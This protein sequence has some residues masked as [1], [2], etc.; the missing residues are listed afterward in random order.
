MNPDYIT[1]VPI[2]SDLSVL[3]VEEWPDPEPIKHTLLP[4][5]TLPLSIIPDPLQGWIRDVC[6]R[7][8]TPLDFV[9]T[10][11]IVMAGSIIG[12]GCG[13][14]PKRLDDWMT[15]WLFLIFGVEQW[16][17]QVCY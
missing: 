12:A 5:E 16:G 6:N 4:V 9:E 14:K 8:Q 10:A 7:M 13:I 17:G 11:S 15:G 3:S 2:E 1:K